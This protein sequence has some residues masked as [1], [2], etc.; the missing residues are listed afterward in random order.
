[1]D[2]HYNQYVTDTENKNIT[3]Y[4]LETLLCSKQKWGDISQLG[5]ELNVSCILHIL[6]HVS[7]IES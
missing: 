3:E 1:M 2:L 6:L 7:V 4:H 5:L